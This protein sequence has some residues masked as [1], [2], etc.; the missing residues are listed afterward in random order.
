M[1]LPNACPTGGRKMWLPF[2]VGKCSMGTPDA[3]EAVQI[4][5]SQ[6]LALWEE[7]VG[8]LRHCVRC[9]V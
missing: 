7:L 9:V 5:R 4:R 1:I 8:E 6:D 3:G 2:G